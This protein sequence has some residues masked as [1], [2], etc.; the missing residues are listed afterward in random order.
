MSHQIYTEEEYQAA[1]RRARLIDNVKQFLI[2]A[3]MLLAF[4]FYV[5]WLI[6]G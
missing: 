6:L 2:G 1:L 5:A 3:A 4:S